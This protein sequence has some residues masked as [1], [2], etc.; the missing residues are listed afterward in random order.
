MSMS[1]QRNEEGVGEGL[2]GATLEISEVLENRLPSTGGGGGGRLHQ[3]LEQGVQIIA[4]P[5]Q[6][7]G[8][9][10]GGALATGHAGQPFVV[11]ACLLTGYTRASPSVTGSLS[12]ADVTNG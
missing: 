10:R 5:R 1:G 12:V 6:R 4:L 11:A 9:L 7:R 8:G 2:R 3:A